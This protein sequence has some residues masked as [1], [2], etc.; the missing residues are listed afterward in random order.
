VSS[1]IDCSE[2]IGCEPLPI[3][4]LTYRPASKEILEVESR[5]IF[6]RSRIHNNSQERKNAFF[7]AHPSRREFGR[8]KLEKSHEIPECL[9]FPL[10]EFPKSLDPDI[11]SP[12]ITKTEIE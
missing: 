9:P 8:D 7:V 2:P 3:A 1:A 6:L 12:E 10:C 4:V 11:F 5:G